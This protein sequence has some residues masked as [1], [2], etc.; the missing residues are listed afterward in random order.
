MSLEELS[1]PD[2]SA[3]ELSAIKAAFLGKPQVT[4]ECFNG[5]VPVAGQPVIG[6]CVLTRVADRGSVIDRAA[7]CSAPQGR[8][9]HVIITG[10]QGAYAYEQRVVTTDT[11]QKTGRVLSRNVVKGHARFLGAC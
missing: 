10:S 8:A 4:R 9:N 11:D 7:T 3:A 2:F 1:G 6:T 5:E